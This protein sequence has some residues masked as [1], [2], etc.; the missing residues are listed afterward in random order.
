M[1]LKYSTEEVVLSNVRYVRDF[2]KGRGPCSDLFTD[3]NFYMVIAEGIAQRWI[4]SIS[5]ALF[6]E[7]VDKSYVTFLFQ[8][9]R[10]PAR[11]L[12]VGEVTLIS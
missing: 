12:W 1:S 7:A 3:A 4:V 6:N 9:T 2:G 11:E 10:P 5:C 8:A